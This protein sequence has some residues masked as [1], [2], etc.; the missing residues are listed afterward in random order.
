MNI[1]FETEFEEDGRWL[2]EVPE[3][4]GV[5][6]NGT[7]VCEAVARAE[8][9]ARRVL[10]DLLEVAGCSPINLHIQINGDL[11]TSPNAP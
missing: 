10:A 5:T 9:L 8:I 6:A 1:T 4:T 2:A 7:T 11:F 3:L